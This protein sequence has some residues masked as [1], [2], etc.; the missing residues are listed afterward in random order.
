MHPSL[1]LGVI[2]VA[3]EEYA[4]CEWSKDYYVLEKTSIKSYQA[5]EIIAKNK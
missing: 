4:V 5:Y 3:T 1:W 2:P